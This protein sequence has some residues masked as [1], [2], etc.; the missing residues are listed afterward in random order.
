MVSE[1]KTLIFNFPKKEIMI[2][3]E[4][5]CDQISQ[6]LAILDIFFNFNSPH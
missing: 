4:N 5:F 6:A 2:R 3:S 1:S